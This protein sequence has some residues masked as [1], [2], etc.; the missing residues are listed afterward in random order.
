MSPE[1]ERLLDLLVVRTFLLAADERLAVAVMIAEIESDGRSAV[2]ERHL[3]YAA[4]LEN[5]AMMV[6]R[7]VIQF[8]KTR[9][10]LF[11]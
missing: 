5:F 2:F 7:N 1:R 4:H 6:H 8:P 9:G 10:H 11:D 3:D